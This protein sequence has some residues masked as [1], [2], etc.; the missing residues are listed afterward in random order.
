MFTNAVNHSRN[1]CCLLG[2]DEYGRINERP[3]IVDPKPYWLSMQHVVIR[4]NGMGPIMERTVH[5]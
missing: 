2:S 3:F 4:E 5:V 1:L